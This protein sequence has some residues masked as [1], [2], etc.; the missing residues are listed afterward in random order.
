MRV[1]DF[2]VGVNTAMDTSL[3]YH[4]TWGGA[5]WCAVTLVCVLRCDLGVRP[6]L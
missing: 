3:L 2:E 5:M 1:E 6:A 4:F